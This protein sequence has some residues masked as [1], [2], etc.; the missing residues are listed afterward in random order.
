MHQ[1]LLEVREILRHRQALL[2]TAHKGLQLG[3]YFYGFTDNLLDCIL[4]LRRM[5]RFKEHAR[6]TEFQSFDQSAE[7]AGSV[8]RAG[9]GP[10]STLPA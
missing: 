8:R 2:L 6:F 10:S 4:E 1:I 3:W 7:A 9:N 5:S